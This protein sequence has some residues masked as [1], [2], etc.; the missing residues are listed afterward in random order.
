MPG[1]LLVPLRPTGLIAVAGAGL[2]LTLAL[3]GLLLSPRLAALVALLAFSQA[4]ALRLRT[5]TE[6][7][8]GRDDP[9]WPDLHD[10]L[11]ALRLH[12]AL[13][14]LFL[15]AVVAGLVARGPAP[16][17]LRLGVADVEVAR[18]TAEARETYQEAARR[19][20]ELT[21]E[22]RAA[23]GVEVEP[24][25]PPERRLTPA[26]PPP[27]A[28]APVAEALAWL[29]ALDPRAAASTHGA[30]ARA[31]LLAAL[32]LHPMALLA[33]AQLQSAAA[34]WH[35]PLLLRSIAITAPGYALVVGLCLAA[36]AA[37]VVGAFALRACLAEGAA[38]LPAAALMLGV[39][40]TTGVALQL[41]T[42]AA[43]GRLYRT[44]RAALAW[45]R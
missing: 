9:T 5:I 26:P 8:N 11:H 44:H 38:G 23:A 45:A 3:V 12:A 10:G 41:V 22:E 7:A 29:R 34:A 39:V 17:D 28:P 32:L 31:L 42:G 1:A 13:A 24:G 27:P 20:L 14:A 4:A 40:S 30:V 16:L 19:P 35:L 36:D 25:P 6:A 33:A 18:L 15:P 2:L 21:R 37:L 43:L